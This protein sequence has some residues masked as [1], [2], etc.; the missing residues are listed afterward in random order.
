MTENRI[1][2]KCS[3]CGRLVAS[4][5]E[6]YQ[7]EEELICPG[8]GAVVAPPGFIARAAEGL[9]EAVEETV[10]GRGHRPDEP[11]PA[12]R[13]RDGETRGQHRRPA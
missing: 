8:C 11:S 5:P 12:D 13:D 9:K 4:V 1:E 10:R 2:L 6:G 7:V 3:N